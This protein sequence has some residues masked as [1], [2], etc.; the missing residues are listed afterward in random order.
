MRAEGTWAEGRPCQQR[1]Q[2]QGEA[3]S[4]YQRAQRV[5]Q[6][7]SILW[8][9][10]TSPLTHFA[11]PAL[12]PAAQAPLCLTPGISLFLPKTHQDLRGPLGMISTGN[13]LPPSAVIPSLC[14]LVIADKAPEL[15]SAALCPSLHLHPC[16]EQQIFTAL[17]PR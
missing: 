14:P 8:D 11:I 7:Q 16:R 5:E 12:G 10:I 1:W 4:H 13:S 17:Q 6:S 3:K 2:E 9:I 15:M